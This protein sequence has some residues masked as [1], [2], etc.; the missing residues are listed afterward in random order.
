MRELTVDVA[1]Q[2][3][4]LLPERATLWK[5][6]RTLIIADT[7]WGAAPA[8]VAGSG[9]ASAAVVDGMA[10]VDAILRRADVRR[11]VFLGDLLEAAEPAAELL[12]LIRRWRNSRREIDMLLVRGNLDRHAAHPPAELEIRTTD[13]PLIEPPFVLTHYPAPSAAGYVLAGHLHPAAATPGE[14][15]PCFW[16]GGRVAVLPAFG[17]AARL[18]TIEPSPDD[19]VYVIA[20]DGVHSL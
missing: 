14:Q 19:G 13:G 1:N 15:R 8:E 17:D 16:F 5:Q 7:H 18:M 20:A 6:A 10:R 11:I 3:L 9:G 12:A 4:I 2:A